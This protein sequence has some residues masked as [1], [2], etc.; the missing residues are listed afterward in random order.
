MEG[1]GGWG[2]GGSAT[3]TVNDSARVAMTSS[4]ESRPNAGTVEGS[5][6]T[7][8]LQKGQF[9]AGT[10]AFALPTQPLQ[11]LDIGTLVSLVIIV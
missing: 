10:T 3:P 4:T 1:L 9:A 6:A 2:S 7:E 11:R 5:A 8:L